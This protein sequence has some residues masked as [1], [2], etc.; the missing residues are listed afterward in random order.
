MSANTDLLAYCGLYCG[1]CPDYTQSIANLARDLKDELDRCKV[2]KAAPAMAKIPT[3]KAFRHYEKFYELLQTMMT[4]R[5]SNPCKRGGGNPDCPIKLCAKA[6]NFE[7]CWQCD[8][9]PKCEKLK[10]IEQFDDPV[11]AKNLKRVKKIGLEQ[12]LK[13]KKLS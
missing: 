10:M 1:T 12:F 13:Q 3:L 7:G 8:S 6:K 9:F 4:L 5:C 11:Y 2:A